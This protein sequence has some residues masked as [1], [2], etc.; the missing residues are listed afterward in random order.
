MILGELRLGLLTIIHLASEAD[1]AEIGL[2]LGDIRR[3]GTT[4]TPP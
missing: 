4:L 1:D 2:I 3:L